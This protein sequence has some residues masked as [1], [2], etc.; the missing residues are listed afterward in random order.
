MLFSILRFRCLY[1]MFFYVFSSSVGGFCA[2]YFDWFYTIGRYP[3]R[4][5]VYCANDTEAC[6]KPELQNCCN[7]VFLPGV[8]TKEHCVITCNNSQ[9]DAWGVTKFRT[10]YRFLLACNCLFFSY[11]LQYTELW[12][13][14]FQFYYHLISQTSGYRSMLIGKWYALSSVMIKFGY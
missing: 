5:G 10:N 8:L 13:I 2:V 11:L 7:G 9:R 14:P 1:F 6:A 3:V 4:V 12:L